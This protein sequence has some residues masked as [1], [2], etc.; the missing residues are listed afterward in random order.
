MYLAK[1]SVYLIISIFLYI[2]S[3]PTLY[4]QENSNEINEIRPTDFSLP[5]APAYLLLDANSPLVSKPGVIRDFKVDW[6]LKSY[7]LA[8]NLAFEAQPI[9]LL[10]Y[11]RADLKKYQHA[12]PFWKTMSTL[13][14][15]AGTLDANDSLRQFAYAAK[16][17]VYRQHDVLNNNSYFKDI[18]EQ[19]LDKETKLT[20]KINILKKELK[21]TKSLEKRDSIDQVLFNVWNE[22]EELKINQ[23]QKIKE[24]Q[25]DYANRHWNSAFID[26]AYG[27]SYTFNRNFARIDSSIANFKKNSFGFWINGSVGI[28]RRF[29]FQV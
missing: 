22:I 23:K 6:S 16:I 19:F 26:I 9:W 10:A 25:T 20:Q 24:R 15:S 14:L 29:Y 3:P 7:K 28:V 8:P 18:V 12:S 2:S 17:T 21:T 4:S 13:S 1:A 11:D 5:P 27:N